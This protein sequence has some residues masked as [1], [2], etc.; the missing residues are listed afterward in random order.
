M[1]KMCKLRFQL[2]RCFRINKTEK[3]P[4]KQRPVQRDRYQNLNYQK[5]K[6][7]WGNMHLSRNWVL[8]TDLFD[9]ILVKYCFNNKNWISQHI[10]IFFLRLCDQD[11]TN[12]LSLFSY[13]MT[14]NFNSKNVLLEDST[15]ITIFERHAKFVDIFLIKEPD[16]KV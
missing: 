8:N 15:L 3:W 2:Q 5:V 16:L 7:Q 4:S 10:N 13:F 12:T 11:V 9:E 14:F 1:L 6:K